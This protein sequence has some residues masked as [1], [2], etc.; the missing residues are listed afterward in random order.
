MTREDKV[1]RFGRIGLVVAAFALVAA[2]VGQPLWEV[3]WPSPIEVTD[4]ARSR[5][6]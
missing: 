1:V 2:V 3:L 4:S 5:I 6:R